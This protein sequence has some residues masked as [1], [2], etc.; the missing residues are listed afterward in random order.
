[1]RQACRE[2][3]LEATDAADY[4]VRKGVPFREAHEAVGAAVRECQRRACTLAALPLAIWRTLH[5]SFGPDLFKALALDQVVAARRTFGGTAPGQVRGAF[6]RAHRR[7]AA[8]RQ[9]RP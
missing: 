4:L 7:L 9:A 2:G 3:F 5:P 6:T 1:M 8:A